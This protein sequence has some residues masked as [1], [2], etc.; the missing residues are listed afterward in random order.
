LSL[1]QVFDAGTD[2]SL[3]RVA[4][5]SLGTGASYTKTRS[6]TIPRGLSGQF[7]V[8]VVTDRGN[9]LAE[10]NELNNTGYDRTSMMVHLLPPADLVVGTITVPANVSPGAATT[11]TYTVRN[12]GA[13]AALGSWYDSIY[14][15]ADR[16]W[17]IG[18][19]FF[20]RVHHQGDVPG[21]GS[22]THTL[23]ASLPAVLPRQ[24]HVIIRSDILNRIPE[25]NE[26]NNVGASLDRVDID[27]RLLE[28]G[29]PQTGNLSEGRAVYYR[30]PVLAAGETLRFRFDGA[31]DAY[32]E[33][34][35]RKG[36]MPSRNQYDYVAKQPFVS[37]Q[38]IVMPVDQA[39]VY[40]VMAYATVAA[41]A[42]AYTISADVI[43]FS[44]RSIHSDRVGNAGWA[45]IKV[46]GARFH[47]D[48][49]F[50]LLDSHCNALPALRTYVQD[51]ATAFVT[52]DLY[53]VHPGVYTVAAHDPVRHLSALLEN[54][55]TVTSGTG[56]SI[57]TRSSGPAVVAPNRN[58]RFDVHFGNDGDADAMAPLLVVTGITNTPLGFS[59]GAM[60][61]GVP[62]QILGTPEEGPLDILRP[63]ALGS[64]P[65]YYR[66]GS[67]AERVNVRVDLFT[68]EDSKVI[69]SAE[70]EQ[71]K[72][73]VKP[74]SI[75][76]ASWDAFWANIPSR[77]G[78]TW[79]HYLRFLNRLATELSVPGWPLRDVR[80][81]FQ[82]L[83]RRDPQY[84]PSVLLS[85]TLLNAA[86][87][88]PIANV[89]L[90]AYRLQSDGTALLVSTATTDAPGG[91]L[92]RRPDGGAVR[93]RL[94]SKGGGFG[95]WGVFH[96]GPRL[97]HEQGFGS[98]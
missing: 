83:Y 95:R 33:L 47:T 45:T 38:E 11:I 28:L 24:Y 94:G 44:I 12:E 97:R 75:A 78:P 73:S 84:L 64:V 15:S 32:T 86:D 17:D 55:L 27:V 93:N 36:A 60:Y 81:M 20:G 19:A 82:M 23:A 56:Y 87:S 91:I 5:Q 35:V 53:P 21:G 70:R 92:F 69:S 34:Y 22:Y 9:H 16:V 41:G 66:S 85:G 77:V 2:I 67:A 30:T 51:S 90:A 76:A 26:A 48:T 71:I 18:D 49:E 58:Y 1:D 68:H 62:L 10:S 50:F 80:G 29:V 40:Y 37:D 65:V 31:E 46:S 14:I 43:P 52:F 61:S 8:F 89:G 88:S 54:S 3:G 96:P 6:F 39:G 74:S 63:G 59:P 79:G 25:R 72:A 4:H 7:Y 42:P 98:G 13:E 57:D